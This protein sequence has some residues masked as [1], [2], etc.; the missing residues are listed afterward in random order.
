MLDVDFDRHI[1]KKFRIA[2]KRNRNKKPRAAALECLPS[3]SNNSTIRRVDPVNDQDDCCISCSESCQSEQLSQDS[4]QTAEKSSKSKH[5]R[6]NHSYTSSKS[7]ERRQKLEYLVQVTPEVKSLDIEAFKDNPR[8]IGHL[9]FVEEIGKFVIIKD[10]NIRHR[11]FYNTETHEVSYKPVD[12]ITE[13]KKKFEKHEPESNEM[14]D[15]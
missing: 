11:L 6:R 9:K 4:S 12:W 5:S 7:D 1:M 10:C 3:R 14:S 8:G 2:S 15:V 13:V